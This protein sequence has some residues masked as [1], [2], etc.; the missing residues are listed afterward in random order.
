MS[1]VSLLNDAGFVNA[2]A[3]SANSDDYKK[4]LII[5]DDPAN[6]YEAKQIAKALGQGEAMLNDGDWIYDGDFL[7]II[8]AD[9]NPNKGPSSSSASSGTGASSD[10][11]SASTSSTGSGAAV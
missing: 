11:S 3:S 6:E 8:G 2:A 9:W 7:V 4:T 1:A 5:Y 10:T